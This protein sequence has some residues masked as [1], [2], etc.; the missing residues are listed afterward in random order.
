MLRYQKRVL[1]VEIPKE[2]FD[3][4]LATPDMVLVSQ[5]RPDAE[6]LISILKCLKAISYVLSLPGRVLVELPRPSALRKRLKH[7]PFEIIIW[8]AK[9]F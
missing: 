6:G 4:I 8:D 7:F 1:N 3:V 5:H 2:G 9:V